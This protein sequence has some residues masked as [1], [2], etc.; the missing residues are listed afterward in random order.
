MA[1]HSDLPTHRTGVQLL[2]LA[3]DRARFANAVRHR[4]HCITGALTKAFP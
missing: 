4:G 2:A 1:L 3:K